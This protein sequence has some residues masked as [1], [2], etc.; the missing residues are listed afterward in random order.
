MKILIIGGTKFLG[1][2]LIGAALGR[3]HEVTLFNRGTKYAGDAGAENVER[4]HGDRNADLDKLTGREWD[5]CID[6]CGYLPQSVAASAEFLRAAVG[7]YIFISSISAY[8]NF[9]AMDFDETA[10]LA[11][12][13][14]EQKERVEKIDPKGELT[15]PVLGEMYGALKALCERAAE[16]A[17]PGRVLVVR[18]GL[19]VGE[20]DWTDRFSYLAEEN[21][22]GIFNATGKSLD[23][24]FGRF[25]EEIGSATGSDARFTWVDEEFLKAENVEAWSE[26]PLYLHPSD[27]DWQGFLAAN[28]D[29][30]VDAGLSFRPLGETIRATLLWRKSIPDELKAGISAGREAELLEKWHAR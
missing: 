3:G 30:A 17:M 9:R 6:T 2:H 18:S 22:C 13:T 24:T 8:A 10:T 21:R 5:V 1:R 4:I 23:L 15:G 12:L 14:A 25:L 27:E 29:R 16:N 11:E 7:Q 28:V 26:M 19:I 20:Y